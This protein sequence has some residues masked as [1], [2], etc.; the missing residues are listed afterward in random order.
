MEENIRLRAILEDYIKN[1]VPKKN[2]NKKSLTE[3]EIQD[4]NDKIG[5]LHRDNIK[6][7]SELRYLEDQNINLQVICQHTFINRLEFPGTRS[8]TKSTTSK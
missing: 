2:P 3:E 7:I 4:Y 1:D 8:K 5:A 6:L